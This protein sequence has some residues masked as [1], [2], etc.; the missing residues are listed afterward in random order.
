MLR[1][2]TCWVLGH[3]WP[4]TLANSTTSFDFKG[5]WVR[6]QQCKHCTL[7]RLVPFWGRHYANV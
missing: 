6:V 1:R 7:K 4:F 3:Q 5:R 2:I